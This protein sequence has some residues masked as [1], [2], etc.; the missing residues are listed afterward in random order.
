MAQSPDDEI[1]LDR[2]MEGTDS[3]PTLPFVALE[4]MKRALRPGGTVLELAQIIELD[5][6]L[7]ARV[8]RVANTFYYSR[9]GRITSLQEALSTLQLPVL[10]S[11]VLSVSVLEL[12]SDQREEYGLDLGELWMHSIG[13]AVWARE[14]AS[15]VQP[16]LD[17]EEAFISGLLH[18]IGKVIL[19]SR[20][21]GRYRQA[22]QEAK[23]KGLRLYEAER[24][25][26][27]FDHAEVSRRAL[28][29]WR[30]PALYRNVVASH[31]HPV[32]VLL[33]DPVELALCRVVRLA[34]QLCYAY[35][36]GRGGDP[37]PPNSSAPFLAELGLSRQQVESLR[38][39]IHRHVREL[40]D[41]LD[42]GPIPL[43]S[44]FPTLRDA[45]RALRDI[46]EEQD[47]RVRTLLERERELAG[48][49]AL[50]QGLQSCRSLEQAA[51]VV[52]ETLLEAFGF[53]RVTCGLY[54]SG[55]WEL[56]AKAWRDA[57]QARCDVG[58]AE[59]RRQTPEAEPG[60]SPVLFLDLIGQEGS[61]GYLWVRPDSGRVVPMEKLGLLLASCA[62]LASEAVEGLH[63]HQRARQLSETLRRSVTQIDEQRTRAEFEAAEKT[64]ILGALP[65]GV[66]LMDA[67][68]RIRLTN[69][70][71]EALFPKGALEPGASFSSVF[72]DPHFGRAQQ[73]VLKGQSVFRGETSL[74]P[75]SEGAPVRLCQW[76]LLASAAR[77]GEGKNLL[78]ILNDVTEE[79]ALQKQLLEAARMASIGELAAGTAHNLRSPLGAVKGMLELL[80]DELESGRIVAYAAG[81]EPLQPTETVREQI[82]LVLRS[83]GKCFSVIDD[84]IQFARSP[85]QPFDRVRLHTLLEGAESLLGEL[86]RTRGIR[87]QKFLDADLVYGRQADLLQ[88]FLN[89]YSNAYKA[90]PQGGVLTV[91]SRP[92]PSTGPDRPFVEILVSDTGCGIPPENLP[93][94]FDPFFTTSDRVEGTG[95]GLSLTLKIVKEHGG[96]IEVLSSRVGQGTTF[97][98]SLPA[99]PQSLWVKPVRPKG[100]P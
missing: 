10:R 54:L 47:K 53:E 64:A 100:E 5:P 52:A 86:F 18:D 96:T 95:L 4:G 16:P 2:E 40:A 78:C 14:L 34:D 97:R 43:A 41:R 90:M 67:Q 89:L 65:V 91:R 73:E 12:F 79:R 13:A 36:T 88:V 58:V 77:P 42:W 66:V 17:P 56:A 46:Q 15:L 74:K 19:C 25:A 1:Q 81:Q 30:I 51:R 24:S 32:P 21:R 98:L 38:A 94:I 93:R 8:L 59:R 85:D 33:P 11:I 48:I 80:L 63:Y 45:N 72:P 60:Q 84:L 35:R 49:N 9:D 6:S 44:Y 83:L 37:N 82:D 26:F 69:P 27:G 39:Q 68:A 3:L 20:L 92:D 57:G 7:T 31:H 29:Q 99:H 55:H 22:L 76:S 23:Q 87:V 70:A 28:E 62:K 50:G 61:L 71:A 75:P